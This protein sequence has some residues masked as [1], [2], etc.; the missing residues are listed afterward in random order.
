MPIKPLAQTVTSIDNKLT[1]AVSSA[2]TT[3]ATYFA[4]QDLAAAIDGRR[5]QGSIV[6]RSR[7]P[8]VKS[9]AGYTRRDGH[10]NQHKWKHGGQQDCFCSF[11]MVRTTISSG[12]L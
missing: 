9:I 5:N 6:P 10:Q 2:T 11:P 4:N 12:G 8:A 1:I 3:T 7:S